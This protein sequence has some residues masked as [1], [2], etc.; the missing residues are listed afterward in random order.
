MRKIYLLLAGLVITASAFAQS[1]C[2]TNSISVDQ[3]V[4]E[5]Q[6]LN[7]L[8]ELKRA[9]LAL[10]TK[11][12]TPKSMS[13]P[14]GGVYTIPVVF[15]IIGTAG[16]PANPTD[17]MID[18]AVADL[19]AAF[20]NTYDNP[21]VPGAFNSVD[22]KIQFVLAQ[23]TPSGGSTTGIYRYDMSGNSAY[24]ADGVSTG[25]SRPGVVFPGFNKWSLIKQT[26]IFDPASYLNIWVVNSING[27]NS[28]IDGAA[29]API[30][31][32]GFDDLLG[33]FI[34]SSA[35]GRDKNGTLIHETGHTFGLFHTFGNS[36]SQTQ[37]DANTDCTLNNDGICDT[38]P[39]GFS[40]VCNPSGV[41][42]CTG[43][44]WATSTVQFNHMSYNGCRDR[45]TAGQS[46]RMSDILNSVNS[47]FKGS[48]GA[49]PFTGIAPKTIPAPTI[50]AGSKNHDYFFGLSYVAFNTIEVFS[51]GYRADASGHVE[52][53][54]HAYNQATTVVAGATYPLNILVPGLNVHGVKVF[55]D[56]NNDGIFSK[57]GQE[58]LYFEKMQSAEQ[59]YFHVFSTNIKIPSTDVTFN[60]PL[61]MRV[62]ADRIDGTFDPQGTLLYGQAE[63]F[64]VTVTNTLPATLTEMKAWSEQNLLN[65]SWKVASEQNVDHY[66][67][68]TSTDGKNFSKMGQVAAKSADGTSASSIDYSFSQNIGNTGLLIS[69]LTL[70]AICLV[71]IKNRSNL[72]KPMAL[73]A[74]GCVMV[75][76]AC[77]K[78]EKVAETK[79]GNIYVKLI[80]VDKDGKNIELGHTVV[81]VK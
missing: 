13:G 32:I 24:V 81:I 8:M 10:G 17:D 29:S 44:T 66:E 12:K 41:N 45:F 50:A 37:C 11:L 77:K 2:V 25:E 22:V 33:V 73:M 34:R 42:P 9:R 5:K 16:K 75:V 18:Q 70:G 30:V 57:T 64:T 71:G 39:I 61:R 72:V 15:H 53:V 79:T 19:N 1:S 35:I 49:F 67:I 7:Y 78:S 6:S 43:K 38:D 74:V 62:V 76:F 47:G 48:Q 54:D 23:R 55:V 14:V 65:V 40:F 4:R 26:G 31:G 21:N 36:Q 63:D 69:L 51:N 80:E 68:H 59:Q 3:R 56:Y 60:T 28:T 52:Y 58:M 20:N 46:T 27:A